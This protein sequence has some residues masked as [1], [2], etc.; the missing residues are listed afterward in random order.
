MI[1]TDRI[2]TA[3]DGIAAAYDA[4]RNKPGSVPFLEQLATRL[5]PDSLILDL[6]CG[7]GVPVDRWLIDAGHRVLGLD[8]SPAMLARA[9]LNVPEAHYEPCNIAELE[10]AQFSVEAVTCFFALFP[11]ERDSHT[12]ILKTIRTFLSAETR[13]PGLLLITTGRIRWEGS[14]DFLGTEMSWS[15]FDGATYEDMLRECGFDIVLSDR[16]R[17]N[18][19][20]ED[21][22]HPIFLARAV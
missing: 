12:R 8:I 18:T 10:P 2:R 15:H 14:E 13:Y 16:H 21:D 6:G 19:P 3:Y 5:E 1:R 4:A 20:D 11:T 22:W 7:A 17:G 9:R